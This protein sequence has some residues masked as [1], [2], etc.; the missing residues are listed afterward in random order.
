[1]M[2]IQDR[3]FWIGYDEILLIRLPTILRREIWDPPVEWTSIIGKIAGSD[4]DNF[5][6]I[7]LYE[8]RCVH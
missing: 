6:E 4:H 5:L 1:M 2:E 3:I 7:D 8:K